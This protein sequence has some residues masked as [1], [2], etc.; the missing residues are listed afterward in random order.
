M[1]IAILLFYILWIAAC[2]HTHD[3]QLAS[4]SDSLTPSDLLNKL[5]PF[6]SDGCPRIATNVSYPQ[7]DQWKLCCV[8]HDRAYWKGGTQ[9][10]RNKADSDLH[11]CIT[12]RGYSEAAR[13][14]YY[15]VRAAQKNPNGSRWG[16]GWV[17]PR[18]FSSHTEN[19]MNEIK[20]MDAEVP[21]DLSRIPTSLQHE[22]NKNESLTGNR[23]VDASLTL[24]QRDLNKNITPTQIYLESKSLVIGYEDSIKIST[25]ECSFPYIFRYHLKGKKDCT[26]KMA[27]LQLDTFEISQTC[28]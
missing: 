3:R 14:V 28:E 11:A 15:T 23:C 5:K 9:E 19:E 26:N 10:D 1:R 20:K 25:R 22:K 27:P 13:L 8:E 7:E 18:G 6:S 17:L 2:A 24:L 16:Y 21:G 4:V 12:Q